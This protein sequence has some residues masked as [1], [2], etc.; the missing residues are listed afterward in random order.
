MFL[1]CVIVLTILKLLHLYT[2][3]TFILTHN[4][5]SVYW[6]GDHTQMAKLGS[7]SGLKGLTS[8]E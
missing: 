7:S 1:C 4:V 6:C 2:G 8:T 5:A 3:G